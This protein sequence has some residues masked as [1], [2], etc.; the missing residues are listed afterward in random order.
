M[1]KSVLVLLSFVPVIVG[2]LVNVLLTVPGIG[3]AGFYLL[4]LAATGFWFYL[5]KQYAR[6]TWKTVPAILIAH[7]AG[8][9]LLLLY[10]WQFLIETDQTRSLVLAGL[11]QMFAA[12]TP[13]YLF[14][15][16]AVLFESQPNYAGRTTFVALQVIAL[17]Y[18]MIIFSAAFFRERKKNAAVW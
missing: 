7:A 10:L 5:G 1:K 4:P 6:C 3:M 14:S 13:M 11:S 9:C 17:A 15:W 18:M 2:Y 16:L 8:I 12:S